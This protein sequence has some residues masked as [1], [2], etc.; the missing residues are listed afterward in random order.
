MGEVR[1]KRALFMNMSEVNQFVDQ[2]AQKT[3]QASSMPAFFNSLKTLSKESF[4]YD[5]KNQAGGRALR[6]PYGHVRYVEYQTK[7]N[8]FVEKLEN[9]S[10]LRALKVETQFQDIFTS[11]EKFAQQERASVTFNRE[12]IA[13]LDQNVWNIQDFFAAIS[14]RFTKEL[15]EADSKNI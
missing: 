13:L 15:N 6:T 4:S 8:A 12:A 10:P 7:L 11:D 2:L 14:Q 9:N 1:A 5:E 3:L